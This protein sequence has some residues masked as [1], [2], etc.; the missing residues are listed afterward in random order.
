MIRTRRM[1]GLLARGLAS[2]LGSGFFPRIPGTAGSVVGLGLGVVLMQG[3]VWLLPVAITI[4]A[5]AGIWAV[6]R[7]GGANDPGWVVIDEIAGM[8]IAMLAL[9]RVTFIGLA[10]A[11]VLFRFLDIVKPGPIGWADRQTG[12]PGVMADDLIAGC[13]AA[14]ILWAVQLQWPGILG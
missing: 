11:L 1:T 3:P 10:A 2:G 5:F 7:A 14:G 8:W 12:A 13:V 6:A 4:A 9:P